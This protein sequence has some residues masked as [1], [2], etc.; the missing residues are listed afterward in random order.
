[1]CLRTKRCSTNSSSNCEVAT[2]TDDEKTFT[3]SE[4]SAINSD[5]S[6]ATKILAVEAK[7]AK[8]CMNYA[9]AIT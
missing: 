6:T 8:A 7:I 9:L 1:M 5:S 2:E 4:V 3:T